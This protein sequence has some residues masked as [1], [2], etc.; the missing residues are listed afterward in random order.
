MLKLL[1]KILILVLISHCSKNDNDTLLNSKKFS[2][3]SEV[4]T[5]NVSQKIHYS[6]NKADSNMSIKRI[7]NVIIKARKNHSYQLEKYDK[8]IFQEYKE[9]FD[10]MEDNEEFFEETSN[11]LLNIEGKLKN[12]NYKKDI[13]AKSQK[14][15]TEYLCSIKINKNPEKLGYVNGNIFGTITCSSEYDSMSRFEEIYL[16]KIGNSYYILDLFIP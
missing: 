7:I 10:D 15:D 2:E 11:L 14:N 16:T 8:N 9:Y 3:T 1:I 12:L 13:T 6:S 5:S 4:K